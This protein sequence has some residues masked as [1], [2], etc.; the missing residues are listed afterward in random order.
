MDADPTQIQQVLMN[1]CTNAAYAMRD[2]PGRLTVTLR[3]T[4][5]NDESAPEHPV[6]A[7]GPYVQLTVQD[8]G[9]GIAETDLPR[10]FE[11]FFTTKPAGEG[12]G[13]GLS[14]VHG[15][16]KDHE[17]AI[18]V[19]SR[20]QVGT[21]FHIYLPALRGTVATESE[22]SHQLQRGRSEHIL[23][24]DDEAP[25]ADMARRLLMQL[26]YR[27]TAFTRPE[28]AVS[29]FMAQPA[30]FALV[31]TDLNMPRVSGLDLARTVHATDPGKPI[32]LVSGFLAGE[33]FPPATET[34]I[35]ET[36]AKP[37]TARQL[38]AAVRRLLDGV[39]PTAG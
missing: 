22:A 4:E 32:L 13:L 37:F 6:L 20:P 26:G 17:G 25:M 16:I 33:Q 7:A 24:V 30:S 10:I 21:T 28:E 35:A 19:S 2:R 39:P 11:P 34:G 14:V 9:V 31:I 3:N 1:L 29:A 23:F 38:S 15:I 27:V 8:T 5:V 36:L 12:T 18:T